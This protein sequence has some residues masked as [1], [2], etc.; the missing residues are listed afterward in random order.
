MIP[1]FLPELEEYQ[2][3]LFHTKEGQPGRD[4]L[5]SRN[6]S[7]TTAKIWNLG[8]CPMDYDARC[9]KSFLKENITYFWRK[10]NNRLIIPI[11]NSNSKLI[12]LSGREINNKWPKYIHYPF[13]AKQNLF[14]LNI[15]KDEIRNE[16]YAVITE[17]QIDV[18]SAWQKDIKTI[19]CSFGAHSS[20]D[21]LALLARYTN[22]IYYIYDNDTAGQ[23]GINF[24]KKIKHADLNIKYCINIFNEK[25]DLDNY[26]QNHTKEDFKKLLNQG[27]NI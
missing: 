16:N 14:G 3:I 1:N 18:I 2:Y 21:H 10:M 15:N 25:E 23:K 26:C 11:Y 17:G 7:P 4:Y 8:Y 5:Q 20:K 22:N 19:T 27:I 12:S 9:Y 24:L 6:I 13:Q